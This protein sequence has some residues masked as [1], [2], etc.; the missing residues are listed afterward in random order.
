MADHLAPIFTSFSRS[1]LSDQC[2]T[3]FGKTVAT[4]LSTTGLS[5]TG[6]YTTG[7]PTTGLPTTGLPTTGLPTTGV[8][9]YIPG[10]PG[11]SDAS[12]SS[13]TQR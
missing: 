5:T 12:S 13:G 1:V 9:D 7:L 6:L 4:I 10:N 2:S 8:R 3:S 11:Q